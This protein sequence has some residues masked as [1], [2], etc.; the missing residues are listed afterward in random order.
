MVDGRFLPQYL[1]LHLRALTFTDSRAR[2]RKLW[3]SFY[4]IS[5][6]NAFDF[7]RTAV[8]LYGEGKPERGTCS[9]SSF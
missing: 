9:T 1:C 7:A 2:A 8:L 5:E 4:S 6:T 3:P